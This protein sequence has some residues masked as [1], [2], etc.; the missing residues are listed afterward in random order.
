MTVPAKCDRA[1]DRNQVVTRKPFALNVTVVM[2][3]AF[4]FETE[5]FNMN[6]KLLKLLSRNARYSV[7]DLAVMTD[8]SE[9][10]V[11]AQIEEMEKKGLIRMDYDAPL[12]GADMSAYAG[13]PVHG[14]ISLTQRGY[15]VLELLETQGIG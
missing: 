3:G 14:S 4:L 1:N 10:Q 6:M 13:F 7:E 2:S 12:K 9:E 15:T 11:K 5:E 8:T